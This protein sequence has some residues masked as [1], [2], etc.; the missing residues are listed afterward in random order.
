MVRVDEKGHIEEN[1]KINY[2]S[3]HRILRLINERFT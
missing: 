2:F 3:D 1:S